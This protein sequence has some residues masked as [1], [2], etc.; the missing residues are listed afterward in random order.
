MALCRK[1]QKEGR[2]YPLQIVVK[3]KWTTILKRDLGNL[4]KNRK[5]QIK[6]IS[7]KNCKIAKIGLFKPEKLCYTIM[8]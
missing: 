4:H 8:V 5:E 7:Q 1:R 6:K 3:I 2:R